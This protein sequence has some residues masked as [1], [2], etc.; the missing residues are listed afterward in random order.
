MK[1][2][3]FCLPALLLVLPAQ[4]ALLADGPTKRTP[5]EA[6]QAFNGLIGKWRGTGQPQGKKN[7]F[8]VEKQDWGWKFK[9]KDAWLTVAFDK[10]RYYQ[11]GELRY[12]ADKD[13][14]QL[15]LVTLQ[16]ETLTYTGPLQKD[17]LTLERRDEKKQETHRLIVKLLHSN[18]FLYH[19][20]SKTAGRT[21]FAKVFGVGVTRDDGSF[22]SGDGKPECIVS[23]GLGTSKVSYMG[24]TYYV[25][26]SGC[27]AEF[28]ADPAKYVKE[29]KEK[30]AK[31]AK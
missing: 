1:L 23:G 24:Q 17:V 15:T 31:K 26:C 11:S 16:K 19:T 20:E 22:A 12:L 6:L 7:D 4:A 29:F 28:N 2:F 3:R 9:D 18:R 30:Q 27:R 10:S 5:R 13:Q 14:F 25:C 8:W 21:T